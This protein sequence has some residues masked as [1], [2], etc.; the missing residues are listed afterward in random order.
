VLLLVLWV[1]TLI[2]VVVLSW[3]QE[4][5][6]ELKLAAG[7]RESQQCR[8]LA[9]AGVYYALGKVAEGKLVEAARLGGES[10]DLPTPKPHAWEGDQSPHRL[11]LPGGWVEMRVADEAGKINL[12]QAPEQI[13][14]NL[15]T[16]LGYRGEVVKTMVDSIL[17]WR[18]R[19]E[20]PRPFGAKSAYYLNLDPP[21]PSRNSRFLQVEELAWVRGF[22][23]RPFWPHLANL[24]TVQ[25]AGRGININT[26]PQEVFQALGFTAD[27]ASLLILRRRSE[28]LQP[29]DLGQLLTDPRLAQLLG[30]QAAP[31]LT[32]KSTGMINNSK[33][34]H[35]IKAIVNMNINAEVPWQIVSWADDYPG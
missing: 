4:W 35:T 11:E 22:A 1:L 9:E 34:R 26:A 2:S 12:N 13:L 32:I 6:T 28:P 19:G 15:F 29:V 33:A 31:F 23:G 30:V 27:Q 21:Y 7:F 18:T 5:R 3:G 10:A 14:E 8:R 16:A 24:L 25:D 20:S 17:D